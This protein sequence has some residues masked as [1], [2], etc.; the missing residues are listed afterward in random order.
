MLSLRL[1]QPQ[2]HVLFAADVVASALDHRVEVGGVDLGESGV[3]VEGAVVLAAASGAVADLIGDHVFVV[4]LQRCRASATSNDSGQRAATEVQV[5]IVVTQAN[6]EPSLPA[7]SED[8]STW[9]M[10]EVLEECVRQTP[11]EVS[12]HSLVPAVASM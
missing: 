5:E 12:A 2:F 10:K 1:E 4:D 8:G 11:L 7:C 6:I 9:A 3:D